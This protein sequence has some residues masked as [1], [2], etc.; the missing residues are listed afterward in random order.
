MLNRPIASAGV[1]LC[2]LWAMPASAQ[3]A[4]A[5]RPAPPAT[6]EV[7]QFAISGNTLLPQSAIDVALV[8]Y[9]GRRTV[10]ELQQAA[11]TVQNLYRDA[12]FG[13]V[14]VYLPEQNFASGQV[15]LKV[16]EGRIRE[17]VVIG[18]QRS[19]TQSLR[20]Q[21]PEL[22]EGRTPQLR[23][24]DA[25]V[26]LANQNPS[27]Q[28]AVVLEPGAATG[29][30]DAR[31]SVV[32][33]A[34]TAWTLSAENTGTEQTGRWRAGAGWRHAD[35]WG[36]SHLL[37]LA[38]QTSIEKA[39]AVRIGSIAYSAPLPAW[40]M[41]LDAYAARS[42]VDGG[43]TAT[44]AGAL[45]FVGRGNVLGVRATRL[46]P[47]IGNLEQRITAGVDHREYLN[48][49]SIAGLPEGACG[50]AGQ[51]VAVTPLTIEYALQRGGDEA[52]GVHVALSRNLDR[53]G[54][55]AAA[56]NFEAVRAGAKPAYTTLRLDAQLQRPLSA[57]GSAWR[58]QLRA[59]AQFTPDALVPGEQFGLAGAGVVRG[60]D[61]REVIG[62]NALAASFELW[63]PELGGA[64][65]LGRGWRALGFVDAGRVSNRHDAQCRTGLT[66][67][68]LAA[69]GIGLRSGPGPWQLRADLAVPLKDGNRSDRHHAKLHVAASVTFD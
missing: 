64:R 62:D 20:D 24:L 59:F 11:L 16:V 6:A 42:N 52:Q 40:A 26:Q 36:R 66:R 61:E 9:R 49:C 57:L 3:P 33:R 39:S 55:H 19:K 47:R 68:T 25:Q 53:G 2:S 43:S 65:W 15:M 63:G 21:L 27:R 35:L 46:L 38:A 50:A 69:V 5:A 30:V 54:R 48:D 31:I 8:P 4:P 1:L 37:S 60:Y 45:Q 41:R 17:I 67:C 29:D 23:T 44:A 51:S 34:A 13:A 56:S 58:W 12:G 28:I 18:A 7:S 22:R 14:I 10:A 32:E